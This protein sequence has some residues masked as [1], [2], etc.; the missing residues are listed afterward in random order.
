[1]YADIKA[2]K[3][4]PD[5]KEKVQLQLVLHDG[6]ANTFH[7]IN[8]KGRAAAIADRDSVKDLL[9][10][11]I[12]KFRRKLSSEL[13]EKNRMLQDNPELFQLYKDLVVTGV[14][15]ADEFW[16]S[17]KNQSN[18]KPEKSQSVGV[19]A[20]FLADI[21]PQ[22]DGC[23]GLKYNLTADIIESI[24]RTY[25]MVKKK[26]AEHVP[27][28]MTESEFWTRF[29]QSHYFHRDRTVMGTKDVFSDCAKSDEKDMKEE[30]SVKM[31][32]PFLDLTKI[33]DSSVHED[34]RGQTEDTR[35]SSNVTNGT[36]IRRFNH[37]ST[38]VLKAC[39]KV[40]QSALNSNQKDHA[41][42]QSNTQNGSD[43][44]KVNGVAREDSEPGTSK[45]YWEP[46]VKKQRLQEKIHMDDLRDTNSK[47][48]VNL[49]LHKMEGYLHGPTPVTLSRY[50]T[51]EDLVQASES[52]MRDV[53]YWSPDLS[54]VL[55]GSRAIVILSELSPGGALMKG[56]SHQQLNQIVP[57]DVQEEVK[58]NY[59]A[60]LELLRH[61]WTCFPVSSK[62]LEEKVIRMKSTLERFQMAKLIP[63]KERLQEYHYTLNLTGHMEELLATANR[64]FDMWQSRKSTAKR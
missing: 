38:M 26:H 29:F 55:Q 7:F 21:K 39:T 22:T 10:Q 49:Q 60:L 43:A 28:D 8:P 27:H 64:K 11:L 9:Q 50:T 57:Q 19:S 63:L 62:S 3:I 58:A 2:Q 34:Y 16:A 37:H 20:A 45:D 31:S 47:K 35:I 48:N 59:S 56:T 52:V 40:S 53:E 17:R 61:F 30:I 6:G 1:M 18:T 4:S 15:T 36:M 54:N 25:P 12:P 33:S 41:S 23:N 51:S 42:Q 24:F 13:E 32:D 5:S 44:P 46:A 14:I